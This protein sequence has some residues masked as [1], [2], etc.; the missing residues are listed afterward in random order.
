[1]TNAH[2][3]KEGIPKSTTYR[4]MTRCDLNKPPTFR[5]S[6]GRPPTVATPKLL[7]AIERSYALNPSTSVP[8]LAKKLHVNRKTLSKIKVYKLNIRAHVK[9]KAPKYIK[10]QK[11]RAKTG[12]RKI[13]KKAASKILVIDYET[14]CAVEPSEVPG[15]KF[16]HA[17]DPREVKYENKILPRAKFSKKY[18]IWLAIDQNGEI[19]SPFITDKTMTGDLYLKECIKKRLMPFIS[20]YEKNSLLF[21]PD[22]AT[23]HYSKKVT[24]YLHQEK[25]EFVSKKENAPNVPQARGIERFWALCKSEYSRRPKPCKNILGFRRVWGQIV[26]SVAAK[27]GKAVMQ[28]A[29]RNLREIGYKGVDKAKVY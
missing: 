17:S 18:M 25:I 14:Y 2:F 11:S 21:W 19:S 24:D 7:R 9:K 5:K 13:Y 29:W 6:T 10:D 28:H 23:C 20:G 12:L 16:Y 8:K 1:M 22:M 15:R 4:W 3:K 26:K 27:S